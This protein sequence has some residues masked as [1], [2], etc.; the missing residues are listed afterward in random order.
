VRAAGTCNV[1]V[2]AGRRLHPT[3]QHAACKLLLVP[4]HVSRQ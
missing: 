3:S 1:H 2:A 4:G